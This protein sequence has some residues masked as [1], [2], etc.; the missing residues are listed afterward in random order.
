[1]C[2]EHSLCNH[3]NC[4]IMDTTISCKCDKLYVDHDDVPCIEKGKSKLCAFFLSF[5]V[6][7]FGVDWFYLSITCLLPLG[8]CCC[9]TLGMVSSCILDNDTAKSGCVGVLLLCV[10]PW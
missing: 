6:G 9:W 8:L 4:T 2:S 10:M 5:F 7:G 1:M 3:E